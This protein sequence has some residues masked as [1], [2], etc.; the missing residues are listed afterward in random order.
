MR[1]KNNPDVVDSLRAVPSFAGLDNTILDA[2]ANAAIQR[3]YEPKQVIF[4]S[5]AL[6]G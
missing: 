5:F 4:F 1:S 6:M 3:N 2:L